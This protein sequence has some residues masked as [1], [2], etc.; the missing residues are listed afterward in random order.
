MRKHAILPIPV[1]QKANSS[2]DSYLTVLTKKKK[3]KIIFKRLVKKYQFSSSFLKVFDFNRQ[4]P[5]RAAGLF[6]PG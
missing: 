6:R 1:V 3:K 4:H 2:T 5:E